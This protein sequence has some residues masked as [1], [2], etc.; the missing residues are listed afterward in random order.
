MFNKVEGAYSHLLSLILTTILI[1]SYP[2]EIYPCPLNLI[3]IE[4]IDYDYLYE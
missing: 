1:N 2:Q 4:E 3:D